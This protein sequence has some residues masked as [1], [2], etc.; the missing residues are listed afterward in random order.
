V[1]FLVMGRVTYIHHYLPTLW[2]AVIM[3][4][5]LLDHFVFK[6]RRLT[7]KFKWLVFFVV[8]GSVIGTFFWFK[9]CAFGIEGPA[10]K[11]N[12]VRWRKVSSAILFATRLRWSIC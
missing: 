10:N 7:Q 5:L 9:D 12:Y 2:F 4:G 1:P 3:V 11:L 8:A 6:S